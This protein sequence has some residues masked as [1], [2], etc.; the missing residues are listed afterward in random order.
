MLIPI[1]KHVLS[2]LKACS[3]NAKTLV[4]A[5]G[6]VVVYSGVNEKIIHNSPIFD[7]W[8]TQSAKVLE[9]PRAHKNDSNDTP[10]NLYVTSLYSRLRPIQVYPSP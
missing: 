1:Y 8:Q 9:L 4:A 2:E 5:S 3:G 7:E 6:M 10:H